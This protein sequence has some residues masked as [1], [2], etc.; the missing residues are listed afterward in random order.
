[1]IFL[2]FPSWKFPAPAKDKDLLSVPP[3]LDERKK[4][5]PHSQSQAELLPP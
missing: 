2:L 1:M 3:P 5:T 4:Q